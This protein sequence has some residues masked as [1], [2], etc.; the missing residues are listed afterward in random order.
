ML[1]PVNSFLITY[2]HEIVSMFLEIRS[3]ASPQVLDAD[4]YVKKSYV[5]EKLGLSVKKELNKT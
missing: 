1:F 4:D 5:I 2:L 3:G